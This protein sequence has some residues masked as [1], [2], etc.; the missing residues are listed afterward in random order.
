LLNA[1][2]LNHLH[3]STFKLQH[4]QIFDASNL[5]VFQS[6]TTRTSNVLFPQ[7][8]LHSCFTAW[9]TQPYLPSSF[10][11]TCPG[12]QLSRQCTNFPARRRIS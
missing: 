10:C 11:H 12:F 2:Q 8:P 7:Q 6:W 9:F 3:Q 1:R 5:H 4:L